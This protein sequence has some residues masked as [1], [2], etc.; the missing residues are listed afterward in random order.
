MHLVTTLYFEAVARLVTNHVL[1]NCNKIVARLLCSK[2]CFFTPS[3]VCF[4]A[5]QALQY[6]RV[7]NSLKSEVKP[8]IYGHLRLSRV[9]FYRLP[10][11]FSHMNII[12]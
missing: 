1:Y 9:N 3:L 6:N 2:K 12:K 11:G 5:N 10:L 7:F 4:L 8:L